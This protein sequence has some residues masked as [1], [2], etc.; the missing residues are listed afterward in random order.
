MTPS[1]R[2]GTALLALGL[3]CLASAGPPAH[4]DAHGQD[5]TD[6][7][8]INVIAP[9]YQKHYGG[10]VIS[11]DFKVLAKLPYMV[12]PAQPLGHGDVISVRPVHLQDDEYLVLQRCLTARCDKASI[13]RLWSAHGSTNHSAHDATR[14]R[15]PRDGKYF[16]YLKKLPTVPF[17]PC[18]QCTDFFARFRQVG[19]P[20][21]LTPTGATT[22]YYTKAL[23]QAAEAPPEKVIAKAHEGAT[24]IAT[25]ASGTKIRLQRMRPADLADSR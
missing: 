23:H 10:Y 4:R 6:L 24:F 25:F 17:P 15:I 20:L 1:I 19:P 7:P 21:T 5:Q 2:L 13:V 18:P 14:M 3:S 9:P 22:A 8:N 11:G 16:L 12:Y